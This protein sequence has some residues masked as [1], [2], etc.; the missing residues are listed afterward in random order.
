MAGGR[1]ARY[2]LVPDERG[3]LDSE[4]GE[5]LLPAEVDKLLARELLDDLAEKDEPLAGIRDLR[6]RSEFDFELFRSA[7]SGTLCGG[8]APSGP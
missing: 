2:D 4:R 8:S 3:I 1:Q 7:S 6:A 5:N